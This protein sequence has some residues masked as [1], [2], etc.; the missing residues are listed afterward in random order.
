MLLGCVFLVLILRLYCSLLRPSMGLKRPPFK[1]HGASIYILDLLVPDETWCGPVLDPETELKT[2][3]D[4]DFTLGTKAL[5][6]PA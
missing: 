2:K 5:E 6:Q 4:T 3:G 1:T